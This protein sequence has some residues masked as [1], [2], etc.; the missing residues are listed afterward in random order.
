MELIKDF[1]TELDRLWRPEPAER[2]QLRIIGSAALMLQ[3]GYERGTKDS[4]ILETAALIGPVGEKLLALA[5]KKSDLSK[6]YGIYLDIVAGGIP[7][8]PIKP[9]FNALPVIG[10]LKNFEITA[11][12]ITDVAVSKLKRFTSNDA[13]DIRAVVEKGL[14]SHA[15]LV[16][17]FRAAVDAYSTDA[18]AEDLPRY[19]KNLHTVERDFLEVAESE[20]DLPG[21]L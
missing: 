10:S 3:A 6:V 20:I 18:R 13:A 12:D 15:L 11:L 19:V 17:R 2:I 9:V 5:G 4:D 21:W 14:I 1:F 7:F 8:L 16:N